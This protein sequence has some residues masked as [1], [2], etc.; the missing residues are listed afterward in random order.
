MTVDGVIARLDVFDSR[1]ITTDRGARIGDGEARVLNIY[2]GRTK[3]VPHFY[4][5]L[6][7]HYIK[8]LDEK[9]VTRLLFETKNAKID[10]YR[11]GRMPEVEYVEGCS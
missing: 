10:N 3:V 5:G 9:S 6:P 8:V 7:D 4:R 11:A 1:E 2:Q